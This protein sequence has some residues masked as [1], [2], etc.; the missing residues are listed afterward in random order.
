MSDNDTGSLGCGCFVLI[1]GIVIL[2]L[3]IYLI[4]FFVIIISLAGAG[5]GGYY[6]IKN[7]VVAFKENIIDSNRNRK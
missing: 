1:I 5:V 4:G 2:Y 7:Y 3:L 6:S